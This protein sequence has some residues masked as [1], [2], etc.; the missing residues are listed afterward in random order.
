MEKNYRYW[1]LTNKNVCHFCGGVFDS[2]GVCNIGKHEKGSFF[3]VPWL[4][5]KA[6]QQKEANVA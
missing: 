2:D 4:D 5:P 1:Y 3:Y 6:T